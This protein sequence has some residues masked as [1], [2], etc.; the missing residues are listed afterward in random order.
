MAFQ[1][2]DELV[3][4]PDFRYDDGSVILVAEENMAFKVHKS[5]LCQHS[6]VFKDMFSLP[7]P[8]D[9]ETISPVVRLPQDSA[10]GMA[11]VLTAIYDNRFFHAH[12]PNILND[13]GDAAYVAQLSAIMPIARKYDI[14]SVLEGCVKG[15]HKIAPIVFPEMARRLERLAS[16]AESSHNGKATILAALRLVDALQL[17]EFIPPLFYQLIAFHTPE[18]IYD[19]PG[20]SWKDKTRCAMG[21]ADLRVEQE[22]ALRLRFAAH[23]DCSKLTRTADEGWV[24]PLCDARPTVSAKFRRTK[25]IVMFDKLEFDPQGSAGAIHCR[26][27]TIRFVAEYEKFQMK[28]WGALPRIFH[29]G[30]TWEDLLQGKVE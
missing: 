15:L 19:M 20:L 8:S 27:C 17:A 6:S 18:E 9:G 16:S 14:G 25:R 10:S 3:F 13:E 7:P 12:L 2:E 28:V 29:V 4:H 1:S 23:G 24:R 22:E 5:I 11:G 21:I 26:D 30:R